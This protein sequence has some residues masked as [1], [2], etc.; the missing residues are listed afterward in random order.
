M[1]WRADHP[2]QLALGLALWSLWFV[3]VY[4]GHALACRA[5]PSAPAITAGLLV[6][7]VA[8]AAGLTWAAWRTGVAARRAPG[9]V[10]RFVACAGAALHG[11]AAASTAFVGLP[12]LMV[13]AC[14]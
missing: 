10:G 6:L 3:A 8:V 5:G 12:V 1:R 9:G 11:I 2:L 7:T 13:P 4:G 14:A